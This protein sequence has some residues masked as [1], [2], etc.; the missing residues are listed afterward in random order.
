MYISQYTC[1]SPSPFNTINLSVV[2]TTHQVE[3]SCSNMMLNSAERY[4][5]LS[6]HIADSYSSKCYTKLGCPKT[7]H[8]N[9]SNYP[10]QSK[11]LPTQHLFL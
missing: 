11:L 2:V 5:R 1:K 4:S 9:Y 8:D 7:S 6:I 10:P 3:Y